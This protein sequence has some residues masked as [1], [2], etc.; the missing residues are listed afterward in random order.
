V[1][2]VLTPG[3]ADSGRSVE[4]VVEVDGAPIAFRQPTSLDLVAIASCDDVETARDLLI[5]RC[6][7]GVDPSEQTIAAVEREIE[8]WAGAFMGAADL[9]CPECHATWKAA[10]DIGAFVWDEIA[11]YARQRL[12]EV[13]E[14]A[15]RYGWSEAEILGLS[16]AR[17]RFYVG[18]V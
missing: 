17:R 14:L 1:D 3:D 12:T 13:D 16:S 9:I 6:I 11:A 5:E 10:L 18:L 4:R 2:V 7:D 8:R 15:R